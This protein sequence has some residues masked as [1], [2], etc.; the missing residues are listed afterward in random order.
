M[1]ADAAWPLGEVNNGSA[2]GVDA[3][4][5]VGAGAGA[6]AGTAAGS[7]VVSQQNSSRRAKNGENTLKA[8]LLLLQRQHE[9][10]KKEREQ[11][12]GTLLGRMKAAMRKGLFLCQWMGFV[13]G[14]RMYL[15]SE[16]REEGWQSELEV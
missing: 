11:E 7:W 9:Q 15:L 14:I 3:G 10:V 8:H 4:V 2:A 13:E 1:S 6:G 16:Q 5:G 12:L